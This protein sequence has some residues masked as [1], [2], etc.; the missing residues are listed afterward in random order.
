MGMP[1]RNTTALFPH[2]AQLEH[3]AVRYMA[4]P[5]Y[6]VC[7][8]EVMGRA[9]AWNRCMSSLTQVLLTPALLLLA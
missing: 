5:L 1:W 7:C 9:E 4:Q 2:T 3:A 8:M 6:F